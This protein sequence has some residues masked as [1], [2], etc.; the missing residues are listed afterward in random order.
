MCP[1]LKLYRCLKTTCRGQ[2][3]LDRTIFPDDLSRLALGK[4]DGYGIMLVL[5]WQSAARSITS[6]SMQVQMSLALSQNPSWVKW[7]PRSR[8]KDYST[9][10]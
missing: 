3:D 6:L 4:L 10:G 5:D 2:E 9:P 8:P 7:D 1:R